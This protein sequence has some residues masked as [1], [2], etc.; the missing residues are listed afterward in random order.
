[1]IWSKLCRLQKVLPSI[2]G[3]CGGGGG[4]NGMDSYYFLGVGVNVDTNALED[5]DVAGGAGR[6]VRPISQEMH[7]G[8]QVGRGSGR[9]RFPAAE[10][11]SASGHIFPA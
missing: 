3:R 5:G 1:M 2:S 4:G 9:N 10:M 7:S 8:R 6:S 11:E